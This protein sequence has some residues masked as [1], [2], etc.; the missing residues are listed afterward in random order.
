MPLREIALT[1]LSWWK[2]ISCTFCIY[3]W[4]YLVKYYK[5]WKFYVKFSWE[6]FRKTVFTVLSW[7]KKNIFKNLYIYI[8]RC[9]KIFGRKIAKW[10]F[11]ES[12]LEKSYLLRSPVEK[13]LFRKFYIYIYIYIYFKKL[14][15]FLSKIFLRA[16]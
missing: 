12:P 5:V 13:R 11:L 1:M 14:L 7:W 3:T 8:F 16:V 9:I 4:V 10:N 15:K 2:Y 6:L